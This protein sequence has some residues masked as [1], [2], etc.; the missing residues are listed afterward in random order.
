ML[1]SLT[2]K[3]VHDK[4]G[5]SIKPGLTACIS[6]LSSNFKKRLGSMIIILTH[7]TQLLANKYGDYIK[8]FDY[9][10]K[11]GEL[12]D[13]FARTLCMKKID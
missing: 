9:T 1:V 6:E 7:H 3:D 12:R 13:I 5:I 2:L 11:R 4:N 10:G 8:I